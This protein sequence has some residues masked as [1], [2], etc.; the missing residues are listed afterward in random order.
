MAAAEM[1][2]HDGRDRGVQPSVRCVVID[3]T[4]PFSQGK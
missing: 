4:C 3:S 2:S 1:Q